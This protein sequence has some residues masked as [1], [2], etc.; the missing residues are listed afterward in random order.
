MGLFHNY[1][2][3]NVITPHVP[4]QSFY[5][6]VIF[7]VMGQGLIGFRVLGLYEIHYFKNLY[8]NWMSL[9]PT[10]SHLLLCTW[11]FLCYGVGDRAQGLGFGVS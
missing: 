10:F 4:H 8:W 5:V 9:L 2:H 1:Y 3:L 7:F 6:C 11:I